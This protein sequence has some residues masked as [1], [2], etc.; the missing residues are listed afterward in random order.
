MATEQVTGG[1][2]DGALH[3]YVELVF[4]HDPIL[5]SVQG[6]DRGH[7]RLGDVEPDA[8]AELAAARAGLLAAAEKEPEAPVGTVRWLEQA[9]LL[10]EL[11]TA[12]RR[13]AVERPWE[14]APYWYAERL[15]DALSVLM[16]PGDQRPETGEALLSRLRQV[17]HYCGQARR[18]LTEETPPLWAEMGCASAKGLQ[19][20]LGTAVP[21]FAR[22][23]PPALNAAIVEASVAASA[24]VEELGQFFGELGERAR[25]QW[26]CGTEH[27]DFLLRTYHHLDLDAEALA[28]HGRELV[29][30]ER[31]ALEAM[32][33]S[34]DGSS[35]WQE[36]VDRIKDWHPE[37]ADFLTSYETQMNLARQHTAEHG[38]LS[39]P[40]GE[41]CRMD[42]VPE[43]QR[44]GLPLG[45]M[46]PSPPYAPGLQSGFLITPAD[47]LADEDRRRQH[48]RDNCYVFATSI[49]GHE[50]YPGHH[51][52]YVHHKLGT[53]RSSIL[54]YFSTPQLVEGWGLYVEDLLEESGFLADDRARLFKRR[55][56]LWRALRV[57]VDVGL[58]SGALTLRSATELMEREAGMD[59]HMAAGE[60]RRYTRHDNPTYPS[61]YILGRDLIH[62]ARASARRQ[63]GAAFTLAAFHDGLLAHGSPPLPLLARMAEASPPGRPERTADA[64]RIADHPL[65]R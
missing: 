4:R 37:P 43:Y 34:R 1:P 26:Q 20:L 61:S 12:V 19:P 8:M 38:L 53:A 55:N 2:D 3:P 24:A 17:P 65:T 46:S 47:E 59:P 16:Q 36:Q 54:R 22:A 64:G 48:M 50:T 51:L 14:R 35:S 29:R 31:A 18:S 15:G 49:A 63:R 9:V 39:M 62:D 27:L 42:W 56:G 10:T 52:Q 30:D 44:D 13:D 28:E 32:A 25:G 11:R 6:D 21:G 5:A 45:V 41:V 40:A 60:V 58:H 57:V 7:A 33:R 23:L